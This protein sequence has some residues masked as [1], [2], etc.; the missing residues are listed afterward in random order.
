M[1]SK[2][3]SAV[4]TNDQAIRVLLSAQFQ[5]AEQWHDYLTTRFRV[6]SPP[7]IE[8]RT[9]VLVIGTSSSFVRMDLMAWNTPSSTSS[10][11]SMESLYKSAR[12]PVMSLADP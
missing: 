2:L 12:R 8:A 11:M 3:A 6:V 4:V 9:G 10:T 7:P 1:P 5:T